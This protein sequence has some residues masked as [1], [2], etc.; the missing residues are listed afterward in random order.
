MGEVIKV[1][2]DERGRFKKVVPDKP[3]KIV[4]RTT[5]RKVTVMNNKRT[6]EVER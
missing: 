5:A 2:R 1:E 3:V 6:T 4:G